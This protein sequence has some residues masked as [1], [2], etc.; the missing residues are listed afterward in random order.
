MNRHSQKLFKEIAMQII[1]I[2]NWL[3]FSSCSY[4]QDE[5]YVGLA[6]VRPDKIM[7]KYNI[8]TYNS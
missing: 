4:G 6:A 1:I 3:A 7:S 5:S 2:I 8:R